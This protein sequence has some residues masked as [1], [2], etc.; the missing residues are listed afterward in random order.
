MCNWNA[1]LKTA[2]LIGV[3][4]LLPATA[5]AATDPSDGEILSQ[6]MAP[7]QQAVSIAAMGLHSVSPE[8]RQVGAGALINLLE[9]VN[10]E[11]Y[12]ATLDA[13]LN[14]P[15]GL[16]NHLTQL[17]STL[18]ER[19]ENGRGELDNY[20]SLLRLAIEPMVAV[21]EDDLSDQETTDAFLTTLVF[22]DSAYDDFQEILQIWEYEIWVNVGESIQSAIDHA[23]PG[24][25]L[26]IKPGVY[27]E[28][29]EID[30]SM[31]LR[32]VGGDVILQPVA[33]QCGILIGNEALVS[34]QGLSVRNA[35]VGIQ[36]SDGVECEIQDVEISDC[37]TAILT[38][39]DAA[40]TVSEGTFEGNGTALY[41]TDNSEM[42]I[43]GCSIEGCWS[44]RA[45]V[46]LEEHARASIDWTKIEGGAGA[47][48]LLL[49]AAVA[50]VRSS[51]IRYNAGDGVVVAGATSLA[52][53]DVGCHGNAGYG[54]R[55]VGAACPYHVIA[56]ASLH[57]GEIACTRCSFGD[58]SSDTANGLGPTCPTDLDYDGL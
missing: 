28:T 14:L 40:V 4:V 30:E 54:L 49:D 11:Y 10:G 27:R 57:T 46:L 47:G 5:H 25:V 9:G 37:T 21:L 41:G 18:E 32:G 56:A 31:T 26:A 39:D 43:Y 24:A 35:S 53:D 13:T 45:V 3:L 7:L 19:G 52:M 55:A 17:G 1:K 16:Y 2:L 34:L 22:L 15:A 51:L 42:T 58:P 12:N 20:I 29:L 50:N 33:G 48:M 44:N 23:W 8:D 36:V 38:L 6:M